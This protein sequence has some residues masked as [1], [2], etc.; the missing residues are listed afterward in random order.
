MAWNPGDE[1]LEQLKTGWT[2]EGL[3]AGQLART[4]GQTRNVIIG[5]VH[6][7]GWAKAGGSAPRPRPVMPTAP[8]KA[9]SPAASP[10]PAPAAAELVLDPINFRRLEDLNDRTHCRF[11]VDGLGPD[12][13]GMY[14]GALRGESPY[15]DGHARIVYQPRVDHKRKKDRR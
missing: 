13:K 1:V 8:R 15:C 12:F 5:I 6:R 4:F 10:T 14:C 11:P 3:S 2:V 7:R 9:A